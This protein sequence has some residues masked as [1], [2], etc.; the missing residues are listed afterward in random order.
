MVF[1][2]SGEAPDT[3]MRGG[4]GGDGARGTISP[5]RG[6]VPESYVG[7]DVSGSTDTDRQV[8]QDG[9]PAST[10]ADETPSSMATVEGDRDRHIGRAGRYGH[11]PAELGAAKPEKRA[12]ELTVEVC[13]ISQ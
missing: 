7:S 1:R 8:T 12:M 5:L 10:L 2:G 6:G 9:A 13:E 3:T 11:R 4:G